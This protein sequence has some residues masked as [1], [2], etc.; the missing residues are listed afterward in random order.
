MGD[1][2]A[3][4]S[5]KNTPVKVKLGVAGMRVGEPAA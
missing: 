3:M 5:M 1:L 4:H 2:Q